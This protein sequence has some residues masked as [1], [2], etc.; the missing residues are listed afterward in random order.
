M[1]CYALGASVW[2]DGEPG[3][4]DTPRVDDGRRPF[5]CCSSVSTL[6]GKVDR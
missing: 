6:E 5:Y 2:L 1:K 3:R 4:D